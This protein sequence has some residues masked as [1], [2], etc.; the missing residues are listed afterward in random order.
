MLAVLGKISR[1]HAICTR[2]WPEVDALLEIPM[3]LLPC[4]ISR[5]LPLA[6]SKTFSLTW[7]RIGPGISESM[8]LTSTAGITLPATTVDGDACGGRLNVGSLEGPA[9]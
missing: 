9:S 4:G 6:L 3:S 1:R 2:C 5:L 8:P 7:A